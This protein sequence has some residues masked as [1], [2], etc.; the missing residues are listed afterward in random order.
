MQQ[1]RIYVINRGVLSLYGVSQDKAHAVTAWTHRRAEFGP[2]I[3][4]LLEEWDNS[5]NTFIRDVTPRTQYVLSLA[6]CMDDIFVGIF[7]TEAEVRAFCAEN[8]PRPPG[9]ADTTPA[10]QRAHDCHNC[11]VS[12]VYGYAVYHVVNGFPVGKR[13]TFYWLDEGWSA[14]VSAEDTNDA[15][16]PSVPLFSAPTAAPQEEWDTHA[17]EGDHTGG[18]PVG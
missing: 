3:R 5:T 13:E 17:H 6:C 8:P 7:D 12:I 15:F 10:I 14:G 18:G 4:V 11:D 9:D 16:R 1:F 2:G